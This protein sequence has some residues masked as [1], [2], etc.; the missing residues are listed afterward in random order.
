MFCIIVANRI[1]FFCEELIPSQNYPEC[2]HLDNSTFT[3]PLKGNKRDITMHV[4]SEDP[5]VTCGFHD[6][7]ENNNYLRVDDKTL[8]H[9]IDKKVSKDKRLT[10]SNFFYK[11]TV[12]LESICSDFSLA[13]FSCD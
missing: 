8:F 2:D 13:L 12:R 5:V 9:F 7:S 10:F 4:D 11:I 3:N 6:V 1:S